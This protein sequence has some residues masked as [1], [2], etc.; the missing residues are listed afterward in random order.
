MFYTYAHYRES[1][2]KPFYI[3]KGQ[4]SRAT[5]KSYRSEAWQKVAREHGVRVQI[6]AHWPTAEEAYSHER[7]LIACFRDMGVELVNQSSGGAGCADVPRSPEARQKISA[8]KIGKKRKP[9]TV[10]RMAE[11]MKAKHR[12]AN[13]AYWS[14]EGRKALGDSVR[15]DKHYAWGKA[16]STEH[17]AKLSASHKGQRHASKLKPV[18]CVETGQRFDCYN[19]AARWLQ[20]TENPKAFGT[21]IGAV[22]RGKL[23]S[24]Y[25]YHW[26]A[27]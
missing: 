13:G 9:E 8:S 2:G 15:G 1:D 21:T 6:L 25:G 16:L 12:S 7:L 20:A 14:E 18:I 3:G 22:V 27:A 23:M 24:A 11:G 17:R 10:A 26:V 19:D 5:A 4:R